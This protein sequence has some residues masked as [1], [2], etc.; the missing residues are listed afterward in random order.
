MSFET[1][2][3]VLEKIL[4]QDKPQCPH[5]QKEMN[6]WEVPLITFSDGLGWGTPYMYMCFNDQCPLYL[7][8]WDNIK[9]NYAH[10]ASYRCICYPDSDNFE[11]IPV[12]SPQGG[13]GQIIDDQAMAEAEVLKENIKK[14][15]S[16]LAEC[17]VSGDGPAI[18]RLLLDVCEPMRVRLKAAEMI[19]DI[20]E[21]EA[22]EP[23]R[24][25]KF[26]NT[27]LQK[28]VEE[29]ITK[30]HQRHYTRECPFCAEIIKKRA[31]ICRYCNREVAGQ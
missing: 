20:G 5:C 31:Q 22:V 10:N 11:C 3:Q 13:Q 25:C 24:N 17:Y 30:I 4:E 15:F 9:E 29:A 7:Q 8:G 14:G 26:P 19:G 16:I 1:K 18:L 27:I 23:I 21:S 12:F 2:E 28:T 6:I